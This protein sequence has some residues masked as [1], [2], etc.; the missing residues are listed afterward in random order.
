M[1]MLS[2]IRS[3]VRVV[4]PVVAFAVV[5]SIGFAQGKTH[6]V[7]PKQAT[8]IALK[9]FPGKALGAAK[10]EHEDG[11]WQYE[12]LVQVGKKMKEVNVDADSG[13]IT[14]VETTSAK[15]EAKE[16]GKGKGKD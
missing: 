10:L 12:V 1:L 2:R 13:K 16:K 14:S 7:S 11:H 5:M 15:E 9:K 6:K 4:A 3:A 8:A